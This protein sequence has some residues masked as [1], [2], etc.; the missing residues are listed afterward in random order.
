[1]S[2]PES[3]YARQPAFTR[4]TVVEIDVPSGKLIA[5]DDLRRVEHFDVDPALSINTGFG[6]DAYAALLAEQRN[7]AYAFVGNTSP[8][9]T[10][11]PDGSLEVVSLDYNEQTDEPVFI[12]D[13]HPIAKI[14]TDLWATMLTDYQN[15]LDHGG[16]DI[17][18]GGQASAIQKFTVIEV[19]P[20]KY[21]WTVFSHND[22]FDMD[23]EGRITY[24][25]L[26]PIDSY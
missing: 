24:A 4:N 12:A 22:S 6:M 9:V 2:D 19:P 11:Q 8:T 16:S 18:A 26:E 21:R 15:W 5:A 1:M 13:E 20:G 25:R 23:A 10:R 7:T 3:Y 14:C 17:S